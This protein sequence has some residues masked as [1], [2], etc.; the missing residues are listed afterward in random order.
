VT[1]VHEHARLGKLELVAEADT[2]TQECVE[3]FMDEYRALDGKFDA[4]GKLVR[5]AVAAGWIVQP[6]L[7]VAEVGKRTS[8]W[9][10]WAG[11][12]VDQL[13]AEATTPDPKYSAPPPATP[14]G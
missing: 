10:T 1:V 7:T 9:V 4:N 5:A 8:Q 14:E 6:A 3:H 12:L 11:R 2:M 13:Y